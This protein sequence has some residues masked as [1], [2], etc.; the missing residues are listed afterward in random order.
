MNITDFIIPVIIAAVP[1]YALFKKVNIIEEFTAG[2]F[3]GIKTAVEILPALILL[4]T[5]VGMFT[6]S[7]T[8]RY[9]GELI[10]PLLNKLG[11]PQECVCLGIIR[12]ISGSGAIAAF[13][14]LL[15]HISPDSYEGRVASVIMGST[16]TT[17]YT[18]TVYFAALRK[19]ADKR[20]VIAS[21]AADFTSFIFAPILVRIFFTY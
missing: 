17:F 12:P 18:I 2:A 5:A 1:A 4:L 10:A 14:N 11:F 19:K 9:L 8:D 7:H 21:L 16:E 3:E 15:K 13:E 6:A 20:I